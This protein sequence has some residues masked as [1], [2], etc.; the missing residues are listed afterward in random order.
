MKNCIPDG[1]MHK[2]FFCVGGAFSID[3]AYRTPGLDWW[4]A[5]ELS[6]EEMNNVINEYERVKPEYV[7]SHDCPKIIG[8]QIFGKNSS[9]K[10][11]SNRTNMG[12]ESMFEIHKPKLWIF[13]HWHDNQVKNILGCEFICLDELNYIDVS[14]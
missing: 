8:E 10:I 4:Q 2:N 6:Y 13:G 5:E 14:V 7:I 11:F 1:T 3:K 12:L 9:T